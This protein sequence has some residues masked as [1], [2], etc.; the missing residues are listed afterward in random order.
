[1]WILNIITSPSQPA[2][3]IAES[4]ISSGTA[5]SSSDGA[6]NTAAIVA[7]IALISVAAASSVLFQ[8][9]KNPPTVQ[10]VQYSGPALSYY[11]DKFTPPPT[12]EASAPSATEEAPP[13][14]TEASVAEAPQP[15]VAADSQQAPP[16]SD[17]SV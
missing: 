4:A 8:V 15:E 17:S 2:V 12:I 9:G 3:Y 10:T 5:G 11:I 7:G 14:Q 13:L 1:M 6:E 16:P